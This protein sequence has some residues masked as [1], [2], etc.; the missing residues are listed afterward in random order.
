[1]NSEK[2]IERSVDSLQ[3][4]Y[5]TVIA[6]AIGISIQNLLVNKSTGLVECDQSTMLRLPLFIAFMAITI[7]F[8]HGMNRHFDRCYLASTADPSTQSALLFDFVVFLIESSLLFMSAVSIRSGILSFLFIA[9]L[10]A[11]DTVWAM[12]SHWIHYKNFEQSSK[13]WSLIN[14]IAIFIMMLLY[15]NSYFS[16]TAKLWLLSS[17]LTART[18]ADYT[19]CWEFYFPKEST[20]QP[21]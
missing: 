4:I 6:L 10:L 9:V 5:S 18:I 16:E 15:L 11:L 17:A 13:L 19:F 21:S 20:S 2:V 8:Y 3:K 12:L 1:M 7:P 14:A